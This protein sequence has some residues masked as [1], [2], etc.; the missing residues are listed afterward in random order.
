[1]DEAIERILDFWFVEVGPGK[2]YKTDPV[3]DAG[4]SA[5]F[6]ALHGRAAAGELGH[7]LETARGA[8]ALLILLDQ[9]S[10]N[11]Y[12]GL[13]GAFDSDALALDYAQQA[14][15]LGH[16]LAF[17]DVERSFFY[18]P[19]M[20]AEDLQAQNKGVAYFKERLPGSTNIPY[21]EEHRD[22]IE[23]FDRFPHRNK[24]LQRESTAAEIAFLENGGFDPT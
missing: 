11:I 14:I 1:M 22:I 9:F 5:Q 21:A 17:E 2:H 18:M 16:D 10:R 20:H 12:R 24:V 4:I 8:L 19:F 13:P 6:G 23:K 7:W 3:L 15:G